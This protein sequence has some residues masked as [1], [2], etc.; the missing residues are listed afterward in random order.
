MAGSANMVTALRS[1]AVDAQFW[2]LVCDDEGWLDQEFAGI[3]GEPAEAP[4]APRRRPVLLVHRRRPGRAR[5]SGRAAFRPVRPAG[6]CADSLRR[7][8]SPPSGTR[9][10]VAAP[11]R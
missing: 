9:R 3:V 2:A 4:V 5:L 7:Q 6:V 11:V 8:R 10:H 1:E